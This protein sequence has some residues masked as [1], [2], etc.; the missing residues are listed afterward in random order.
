MIEVNFQQL[1]PMKLPLIK[2]IYKHFY[3]SA[4]P[5]KSE[6][7]VVG[8]VQQQIISVVRF[9]PIEHY[10]LL[11]GL[12]VIP[13]YRQQGIA[14]QLLN[15]CH[16][17]HVNSDTFCFAYEHLECLYQSCGFITIT[18][19]TLPPSLQQLFQRYTANGKKLLPMQ[20]KATVLT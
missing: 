11:T 20:Y 19:E 9:R 16:K 15:F 12:L 10:S 5:K 3:P 14:H 4:K 2:P 13:E 18:P 8:Y 1:D 17:D 6:V 7:I